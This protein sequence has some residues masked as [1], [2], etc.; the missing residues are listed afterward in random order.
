M[1][2]FAAS[3]RFR[4]ECQAI[5]AAAERGVIRNSDVDTQKMRDRSERPLHLA[6]PEAKNQPQY[7][8]GLIA[9]SE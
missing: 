3:N 7:Q 2:R 8:A 6:Q 9:K 1:Q 4:Q 5:R